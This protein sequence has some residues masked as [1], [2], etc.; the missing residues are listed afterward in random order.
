[1]TRGGLRLGRGVLWTSTGILVLSAH[2]AVAGWAMRHQRPDVAIAPEAFMIDMAPPPG[3]AE[4]APAVQDEPQVEPEADPP[5]PAAEPEPE[6]QPQPEPGPEAEPEPEPVPQP[7]PQP[8][9]EPQPDFVPPPVVPLPPPDFASLVPPLPAQP[10]PAPDF[11]PPPL[12]TLPPPDFAALA[13][14][15]EPSVV[16]PP[17]RKPTPP[18]SFAA[19][20]PEPDPEPQPEPD[21]PRRERARREE[22]R[23][24]A[25]DE[26]REQAS[27]P[28]R[29]APRGAQPDG[30]EAERAA[31]ET[32]QS[33]GASKQGQ[34]NWLGK[35]QSR[36]TAHMKR[37]CLNATGTHRA[38]V[39]L[40]VSPNGSVSAKLVAGTGDARVDAALS[41][42]ASRIPRL[43]PPPDGRTQTLTVPFLVE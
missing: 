28:R 11:T 17:R 40:T 15:A 12:T 24:P 25:R 9:A 1:M 10:E 37:A 14:P 27:E 20:E 13:S 38:T 19:Q 39:T 5:E 41:R 4:A 23:E 34:A 6:P 3:P 30:R 35:V 43:P 36:V 42:Q 31:A 33:R 22:P 21:E 7:I 26:P 32:R 16:P 2:V 29:Q 18:A 8:V